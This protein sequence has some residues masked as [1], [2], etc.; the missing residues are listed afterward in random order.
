MLKGNSNTSYSHAIVNGH[1]QKC[2]I[3]RLIIDQGEID[4]QKDLVEYIYQFYKDLMGSVGEERVL[5]LAPNL[6]EEDSKIS[7]EENQDLE[8]TFIPKELDDMLLSMNLDSALGLNGLP[9]VFFKKFW[10][11]LKRPIL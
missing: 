3:P 10:A 5:S 7:P 2:S 6:W 1:R 9:V 11:I 4:D 8:L